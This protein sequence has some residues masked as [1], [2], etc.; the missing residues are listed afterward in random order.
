MTV[1]SGGW[2]TVADFYNGLSVEHREFA[3]LR[4]FVNRLAASGYASGLHPWTSMHEFCVSQVP[5][6]G[7]HAQPHLRVSVKDGMLEF[8]YV[9]TAI[10]ERQ[11][12]RT[13]PAEYGYDR[14]VSFV[15]ELNWFGRVRPGNES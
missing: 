6:S 12:V 3:C 10:R 8:R 15:D 11:W 5:S 14:F 13:V 2:G 1:D 7:R 9:D 4:D